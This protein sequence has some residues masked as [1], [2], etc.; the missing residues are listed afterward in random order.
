MADLI[1]IIETA[2]WS[3]RHSVLKVTKSRRFRKKNERAEREKEERAAQ[4]QKEEN[5]REREEQAAH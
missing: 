3:I 2:M 1:K 5:D 4:R